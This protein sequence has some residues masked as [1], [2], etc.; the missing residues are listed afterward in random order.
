MKEF[1]KIMGKDLMD[2]GFSTKEYVVYGV[3]APIMLIAIMVLAGWLET[4]CV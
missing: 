4:R 3:V 2:E 1:M